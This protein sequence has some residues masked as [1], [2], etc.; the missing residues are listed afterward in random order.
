MSERDLYGVPPADE[1]ETEPA[2]PLPRQAPRDQG[3]EWSGEV[4]ALLRPAE[5]GV[6]FGEETLDDL[7][8]P[9][10]AEPDSSGGG[11]VALGALAGLLAAIAGAV[12]WGLI[13]DWTD[14]ELAVVAW[15]V[16]VLVACAIR[17]VAGRGGPDLQMIAVVE[18]AAA[19]LVGKYLAFVFVFRSAFGTNLGIFSAD[20]LDVYR[21]SLAD[22]F[23]LVDVLWIALALASAWT[24]LLTAD[25]SEAARGAPAEATRD[26]HTRNP[27][28][29]LTRGLPAAF[30][31]P[32]IGW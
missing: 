22:V 11:S 29:R 21:N 19:I 2:R 10:A 14:R 32:S 27:V 6:S 31:S 20:T 18:S 4:P 3:E 23:G 25:E 28:D 17:L 9:P 5:D 26:Y 1:S 24:I 16:G 15:G 30:A 7:D 13:A 12:A 8:T